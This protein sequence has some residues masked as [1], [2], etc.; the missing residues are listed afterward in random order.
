MLRTLLP[1]I[2]LAAIAV[3]LGRNSRAALVTT[4]ALF[5]LLNASTNL[6]VYI[7]TGPKFREA[8]LHL[9]TKASA[10]KYAAGVLF[11]STKPTRAHV[12]IDL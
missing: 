6:L 1:N 10:S 4:I 12:S 3:G 7:Y 8:L 2:V 11:S 9:F 5:N